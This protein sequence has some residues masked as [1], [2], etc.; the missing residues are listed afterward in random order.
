[1]KK[2]QSYPVEISS[3]PDGFLLTTSQWVPRPIQEVF[4]FFSVET[5]LETLTPEFVG[6]KVLGKS[7]PTV[8]EGTL[9]D[10]TI[11]LHGIPMKWTTQIESWEPGVRFTDTQ[12]RGPYALW[13]HTHEFLIQDGGTLMR[14]KVL[15]KLPF[16]AL[17]A[18]LAGWM[19]KR[20]VRAIFEYRHQRVN[21]IFA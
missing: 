3:T 10:Y 2:P 18:L 13:H 20:D 12:L 19:V 11:K 8:G 15:F 21:S 5:N 6:F 14:D 9:I 1:M 7:T 16:G 17:G 4:Q